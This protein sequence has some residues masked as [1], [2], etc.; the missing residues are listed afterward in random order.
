MFYWLLDRFAPLL[1]QLELHASGD[2]HVFLT[3]RI[4]LASVSS[5]V[6]AIALGPLAIR[7]LKRR[8]RERIDSGSERLNELHA[9][10]SSTPTMGGLFVVGSILV[11]T[12]LWADLSNSY[13]QLALFTAFS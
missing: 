1:E 2:S 3:A 8:F 12:V 9:G 13:I 10:K 6:M 11:A 7:W 5:F 4:A